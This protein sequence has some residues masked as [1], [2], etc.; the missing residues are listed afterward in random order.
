MFESLRTKLAAAQRST[1]AREEGF[2]SIKQLKSNKA[3]H[4]A[5]FPDKRIPYKIEAWIPKNLTKK[6][7]RP[8]AS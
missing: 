8:K 7:G 4:F 2:G 1:D 5:R 3:G 6:P